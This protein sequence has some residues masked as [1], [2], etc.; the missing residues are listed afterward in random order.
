MDIH[1]CILMQ[2]FNPGA[3]VPPVPPQ[4]IARFNNRNLTPEDIVRM[5]RSKEFDATAVLAR[6]RELR[7]AAILAKP[8]IPRAASVAA[9]M[10]DEQVATTFSFMARFG[11]DVFQ[12]DIIG[13]DPSS[14]YNHIH[15]HIAIQSFIALVDVYAYASLGVN[16]KYAVDRS[17]LALL[18]RLY[19]NY[20]WNYLM[21]QSRQEAR[22]HGSAASKLERTAEYKRRDA[23]SVLVISIN[24]LTERR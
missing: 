23:V 15:R 20:V 18:E 4:V 5:L 2:K 22:V 17:H 19:D 14:S 12:P 1:I 9:S 3:V 24:Q 11:L 13:G 6:A 10:T 21:K 8:P 16:R 7:R